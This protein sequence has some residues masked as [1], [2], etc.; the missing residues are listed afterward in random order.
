MKWTKEQEDLF[1]R[2]YTEVFPIIARVTARITNSREAAEEVCH[3]AMIRYYHRLDQIPDENQAKYW[4]I[5]VSKN[6]ALNYVKRKKRERKAYERL[7]KEPVR[8]Q[9]SGEDLTIRSETREEVQQAL[10]KIPEK[11]RVVLVMKEYG[12][13]SYRE[14]GEVLGLSEG[15]VKVRAFRGR[16]KLAEVLKRGGSGYGA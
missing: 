2:V 9:K 6:L 15:N 16:E 3:E 12:D 5:R 10:E 1:Y 14:I 7:L 11:Y 4:L 8:D 13:L